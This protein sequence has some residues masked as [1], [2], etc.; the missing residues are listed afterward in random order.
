[1]FALAYVILPFSETAPAD[2]IQSS[3]ARFQRGLRGDVP[4]SWIQFEDCTEFLRSAH[5]AKFVFTLTGTGGLSIQGGNDVDWFID[6]DKVQDEMRRR[7]LNS[8]SVRFADTMDIET[9]HD[10]FCRQQDRNPETGGF[11]TN[12]NGLGRWDW[13]DLGGRFDGHIVGDARRAEGRGVAKVRSPGK[14]RGR[15]ILGNLD[16]VLGAALGQEPAAV[17]DIRS[18]RNIE[19]VA[20]LLAAGRAGEGHAIPGALVLPP[21]NVEDDMRWLDYWPET[22]PAKGIASLG[23]PADAPW[24]EVV[25]AAY[26]KFEDHWAAGVSYHL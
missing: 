2:A 3:L 7:E 9:F 26:S 18:D 20:T 16:R 13:W 1:M 12:R 11:G 19:L 25:L 4:D 21:G 17:F 23:L 8:W 10:R 14:S 24:S 5:E 6:F 22:G 15:T